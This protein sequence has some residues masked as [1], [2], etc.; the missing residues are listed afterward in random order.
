MHEGMID[1]H[2]YMY[3]LKREKNFYRYIT[4]LSVVTTLIYADACVRFTAATC[5]PEDK[6]EIIQLE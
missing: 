6:S 3:S 2:S 5:P 1:H 4:K